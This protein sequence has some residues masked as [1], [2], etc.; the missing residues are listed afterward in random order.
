MLRN[1]ANRHKAVS[2]DFEQWNYAFTNTFAEDEAR[3]LYQRYAVPVSG[4]ILFETALANLTPGHAGTWVDYHNDARA[5]LLFVAGT[6]DN[7]MP[8]KVQWSNAAHYK[9]E[10]PDRGRGVRRQ[11]A[12]AARG[13]GLGGD[14]RLRAGLGAA[15]RPQLSRRSQRLRPPGSTTTFVHKMNENVT[16]GTGCRKLPTQLARP[17]PEAGTA[18]DDRRFSRDAPCPIRPR[19]RVHL[20]RLHPRRRSVP[21]GCTSR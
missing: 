10:T 1:P 2:Y 5:P 11:A 19:H 17:V 12:P 6:E 16:S 7:I 4:R 8:P 20:P 21:T 9:A 3:Q 13:P 14:R 18:V 15:A